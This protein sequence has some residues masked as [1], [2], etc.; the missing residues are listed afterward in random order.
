MTQPRQCVRGFFVEACLFHGNA[1]VVPRCCRK[2]ATK[3][4]R[5]MCAAADAF[6]LLE[7]P[8]RRRTT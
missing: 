6:Q 2:P 7:H 3:G 4:L 5:L 8:Q 1:G